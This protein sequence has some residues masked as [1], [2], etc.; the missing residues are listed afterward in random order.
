MYHSRRAR[1]RQKAVHFTQDMQE[2][3]RS[4]FEFTP[5]SLSQIGRDQL[6]RAAGCFRRHEL[7]PGIITSGTQTPS[8]A[9]TKRLGGELANRVR[10]PLGCCSICHPR[11]HFLPRTVVVSG[12]VWT[13]LE[14]P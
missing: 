5:S 6:R 2:G 7:L 9:E 10:G 1:E 3:E 12:P 4:V 8:A 11:F 14:I 13:G